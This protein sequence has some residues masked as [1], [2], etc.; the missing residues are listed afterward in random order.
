[1][2]LVAGST[3]TT[4]HAEDA[5][6]RR[7]EVIDRDVEAN[8]DDDRVAHGVFHIAGLIDLV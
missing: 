4:E 1:M 5:K 8:G 6:K 7:E 2:M 3:P